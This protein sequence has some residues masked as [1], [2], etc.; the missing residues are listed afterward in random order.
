MRR[1]TVRIPDQCAILI[2]GFKDFDAATAYLP[3]IRK[4]PLPELKLSGGKCPYDMMLANVY[5][6]Q[7]HV[8][9]GKQVQVPVNPFASAMVVRNPSVPS[10][11]QQ[12]Q[13]FDPLWVKFN[14]GEDYSLL[15]CS[16][17]WTLIV[18]EY[19][20][21]AILQGGPK[22]GSTGFLASLGLGGDE[23]SDRLGASAKQAHELAKFLRDRRFGFETYV[24]HTRRSSV[25]AVGAFDGPN[26]PEMARTA[27]RLKKLT[28][29]GFKSNMVA[30]DPIGLRTEPVPF[31]IPRP[32]K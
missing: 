17:P 31:E 14:E 22:T 20:S 32:D 8:T 21:A 13:K 3:E 30:G 23:S 6:P 16:K 28:S 15:K 18:K 19:A 10:N 12:K 25:V 24:L 27:E 26:D 7:K 9:T 11:V 1:K 2:G 4:L 5:D 29:L